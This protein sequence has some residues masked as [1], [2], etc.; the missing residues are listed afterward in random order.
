ML[1][2]F[3]EGNTLFIFLFTLG[4]FKRDHLSVPGVGLLRER[5]MEIKEAKEDKD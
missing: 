2:N 5:D 4:K 3:D 1:H